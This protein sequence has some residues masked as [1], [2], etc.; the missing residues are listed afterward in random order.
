MGCKKAFKDNP[1][2]NKILFII[3]D[4]L[5]NDTNDLISA[6]QQIKEKLDALKIITICI[7]VNASDELNNKTFY[8]EI[9][10]NFDC[11]AKFLFNISSQLDYHNRIIIFFIK[12]I[13]IF[14]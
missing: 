4:G 13:G 7:Y 10:P 8:N 6:Q 9:Q 14:L 3:S 2:N 5:L 1:S 12:K 11:G